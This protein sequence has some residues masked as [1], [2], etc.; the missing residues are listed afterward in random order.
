MAEDGF[1]DYSSF[2]TPRHDA[3]EIL[4]LVNVGHDLQ[5]PLCHEQV[6]LLRPKLSSRGLSW[7]LSDQMKVHDRMP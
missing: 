1:S 4:P 3:S 2:S 6:C 5:N 7:E